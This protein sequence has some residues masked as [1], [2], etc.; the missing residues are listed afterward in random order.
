MVQFYRGHALSRGSD[1][2]KCSKR[3]VS[4][5]DDK[6]DVCVLVVVNNS[7]SRQI[8]VQKK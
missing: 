1:P 8:T 2:V 4:V 3:R 7:C 5:V 6:S